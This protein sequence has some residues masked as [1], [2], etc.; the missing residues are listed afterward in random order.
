MLRRTA[1]V[2]V[3]YLGW[4]CTT[5]A[6]SGR[7]NEAESSHGSSR[8]TT[9]VTSSTTQSS[10]SSDLGTLTTGAQSDSS[11]HESESGHDTGTESD[12]CGLDPRAMATSIEVQGSPRSFVLD[13]PE[14]YDPARRYP[15]IFAWHGLGGSGSTAQRYFGFED[16]TAALVVYPDGLPTDTGDTGWVLDPS[17]RDVALFDR[18]KTHVSAHAC[19]DERYL[20]STGHSFGGFMSHTLGCYRGENLAAIAPVAG[21]LV[22]RFGV[23]TGEVA[24]WSS[25]GR[26]DAVVDL[27]Q[28][29]RAR[30]F[31]RER[32]ACSLD[33]VPADPSPCI[34]YRECRRPLQWCLHEDGHLWPEFAGPAIWQFFASIR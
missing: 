3:A 15:L 24:V 18:L 28:G 13:V 5:T 27:S 8:G 4:G 10:S 32:L 31:W 19:V 29:E 16:L 17:G 6:C 26:R 11:T 14:D 34:A 7:G 12:G 20:F 21:G 1:T 30:D 25:H 23:C 22:Q 33:A 2:L 9:G